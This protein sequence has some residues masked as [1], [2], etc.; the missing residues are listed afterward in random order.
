MKQQLAKIQDKKEA[1]TT[2]NHCDLHKCSASSVCQTSAPGGFEGFAF[3]TS[4]S[5]IVN[6]FCVALS[7]WSLRYVAASAMALPHR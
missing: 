7:R 2:S 1:E 3:L 6:D 4:F 5:L